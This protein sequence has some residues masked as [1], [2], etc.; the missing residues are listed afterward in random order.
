VPI[1]LGASA[2]L[3]SSTRASAP[4][5]SIQ[6]YSAGRRPKSAKLKRPNWTLRRRPQTWAQRRL[7]GKG[8]VAAQW[9]RVAQTWPDGWKESAA[10]GWWLEID[11]AANKSRTHSFL[12]AALW[13][14]LLAGLYTV[15]ARNWP[16]RQQRQ[17]PFVVL[18]MSRCFGGAFGCKWV[19]L[20]GSIE[21]WRRWKRS[22]RL[23]AEKLERVGEFWHKIAQIRLSSFAC[24]A[25]NGAQTHNG[26]SLL[27][28]RVH[29][30][31]LCA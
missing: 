7:T 4:Q 15:N 17:S 31:R 28:V 8:R 24:G 9:Q 26:H 18:E 16:T 3:A 23:S 5:F 19:H 11:S 14:F 2:E 27:A 22:E 6:F 30:A 12:L 13:S 21:L 29:R 20:G 10:G 1:W 25:Q